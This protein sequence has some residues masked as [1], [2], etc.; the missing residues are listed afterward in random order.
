MNYANHNHTSDYLD[1]MYSNGFTPVIN[2]ELILSSSDKL[3]TLR[4]G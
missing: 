1:I 2:V 4:W 3:C